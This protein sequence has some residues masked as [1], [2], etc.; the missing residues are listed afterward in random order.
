MGGGSGITSQR[1]A[2]KAPVARPKLVMTVA[3][4]FQRDAMSFS[5]GV[6]ICESCAGSESGKF[7]MIEEDRC[8]VTTLLEED[9][10]LYFPH[11]RL[12]VRLGHPAIRYCRLGRSTR[13]EP[14]L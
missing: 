8:F 7:S 13:R 3:M 11:R 4:N 9:N 12:Q 1:S 2:A 14:P 10:A 6:A 5:S